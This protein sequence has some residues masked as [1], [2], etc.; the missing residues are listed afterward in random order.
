M[1]QSISIFFVTF[2][3]ESQQTTSDIKYYNVYNEMHHVYTQY[4]AQNIT[5]VDRLYA[6]IMQIKKNPEIIGAVVLIS[7]RNTIAILRTM[8]S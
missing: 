5:Q 8:S 6:D 2:E 4:G 3:L 7:L 1:T